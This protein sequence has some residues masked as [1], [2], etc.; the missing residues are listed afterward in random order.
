MAGDQARQTRAAAIPGGQATHVGRQEGP[1]RARHQHPRHDPRRQLLPRRGRPRH[2]GRGGVHRRTRPR[3]HGRTR[4]RGRPGHRGDPGP[5]HVETHHVEDD[6]HTGR[7]AARHRGSAHGPTR[8]DPSRQRDRRTGRR[9]VHQAHPDPVLPARGRGRRPGNR[10]RRRTHRVRPARAGPVHHAGR[11]R[12]RTRGHG[13]VRRDRRGPLHARGRGPRPRRV[14]VRP[15]R[16]SLGRPDGRGRSHAVRH[17][18]RRRAHRRR[19]H[20]QDHHHAGHGGPVASGQ[21]A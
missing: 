9:P 16:T 8:Q 3:P 2:G 4:H 18:A 10:R 15:R 21:R 1:G 11:A 17:H 13:R 20:R 19:R 5:R 6:Q 7:G 12:R 14:E